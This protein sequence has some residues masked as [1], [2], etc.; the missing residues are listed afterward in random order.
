M[1][2]IIVAFS[3]LLR[4]TVFSLTKFVFTSIVVYSGLYR[5]WI[6]FHDEWRSE[7][8]MRKTELKVREMKDNV[9]K[10]KRKRA[11]RRAEL[12][13]EGDE[14]D[15]QEYASHKAKQAS[16]ETSRRGFW[17]RLSGAWSSPS[18]EG[19]TTTTTESIP[20]GK[21][22]GPETS[23]HGGHGGQ[24]VSGPPSMVSNV[25]TQVNASSRIYGGNTPISHGANTPEPGLAGGRRRDTGDLV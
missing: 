11:A 5:I 2:T 1:A 21:H 8:L 14:P 24:R 7:S 23:E 3:P 4:A 22:E 13:G 20:N 10:A 17:S 9:R 19:Q 18:I 16:S 6:T 15:S 12:L 25:T